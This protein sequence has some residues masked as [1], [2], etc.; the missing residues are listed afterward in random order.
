M[1]GGVYHVKTRWVQK[2]SESDHG[3]LGEKKKKKQTPR[4]GSRRSGKSK[5][6]DMR[7]I[8]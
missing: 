8:T 4:L 3:G 6:S 5:V 2:N 7:M 1:D